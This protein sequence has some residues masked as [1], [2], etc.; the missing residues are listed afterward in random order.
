MSLTG[1]AILHNFTPFTPMRN[2]HSLLYRGRTRNGPA[3]QGYFVFSLPADAEVG[4]LH[5]RLESPAPRRWTHPVE[6]L[7]ERFINSVVRQDQ[8]VRDNGRVSV[9]VPTEKP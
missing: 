9:E 8:L 5:V 7:D 6:S 2:Q 4:S 1:Y 3:S